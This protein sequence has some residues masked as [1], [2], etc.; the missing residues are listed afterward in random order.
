MLNQVG[1][2]FK[3]DEEATEEDGTLQ[4]ELSAQVS[5]QNYENLGAVVHDH[6]VPKKNSDP[7]N[8]NS[9][10][11]DTH[12]LTQLVLDM[13]LKAEM[14]TMCKAMT[15]SGISFDRSPSLTYNLKRV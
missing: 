13:N 1:G 11:Q 10:S 6:T 3:L 8:Q 15:R 12:K 2:I 7:R 4:A 5:R 14:G 9:R